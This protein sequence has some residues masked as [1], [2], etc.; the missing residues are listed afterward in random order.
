MKSKLMYGMVLSLSALFFSACEK[1]TEVQT[2]NEK[3]ITSSRDEDLSVGYYHNEILDEIIFTYRD[4]TADNEEAIY[5]DIK[6]LTETYKPGYDVFSYADFDHYRSAYIPNSYLSMEDAMSVVGTT[7]IG[8]VA[9]NLYADGL[10]SSAEKAYYT[11]FGDEF[12]AT[13]DYDGAKATIDSYISAIRLD[14]AL[15]EAE[16]LRLEQSFDIGLFSLLYWETEAALGTSSSWDVISRLSEDR[17]PPRWLT[18][19]LKVGADICGGAVGAGVGSLAGPV[20]TV[21]GALAGGSAASAFMF[22]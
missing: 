13:T 19:L 6:A 18:V 22:N 10:M 16:A 7:L 3:E 17:R 1:D 9:A 12:F 5:A 8:D 15:S 11:D 2:V 20:G 14:D 4:V 21:G